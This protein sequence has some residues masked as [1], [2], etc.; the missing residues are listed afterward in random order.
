MPTDP[1]PTDPWENVDLQI[2]AFVLSAHDA[3]I[4]RAEIE[5]A[6]AA[7][8]QQHQAELTRAVLRYTVKGFTA[9][10]NTDAKVWRQRAEQAEATVRA[11][12]HTNE[13]LQTRMAALDPNHQRRDVQVPK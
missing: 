6:R 2:A 11:L 12:Q 3:R 4:L 8:R 9:G 1:P 5:H 10:E 13:E 7:E